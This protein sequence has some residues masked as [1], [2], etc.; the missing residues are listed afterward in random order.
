MNGEFLGVTKAS[1]HG[2]NSFPE[3]TIFIPDNPEFWLWFPR[4]TS[5]DVG[6]LIQANFSP[7]NEVDNTE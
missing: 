6:L 1:C 3:S 2:I 7:V 4:I 5:T